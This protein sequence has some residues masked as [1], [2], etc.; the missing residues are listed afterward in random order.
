M[1]T[2]PLRCILNQLTGFNMIVVNGLTAQNC[3]LISVNLFSGRFFKFSLLLKQRPEFL[4]E[5]FQDVS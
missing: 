1:E 4:I 5:V 2:I 3:L